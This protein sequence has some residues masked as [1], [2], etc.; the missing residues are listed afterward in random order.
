MDK[1]KMSLIGLGSA[2][3]RFHLQNL[4]GFDDVDVSVC[5]ANADR[6]KKISDENGIQGRSC[7][8]G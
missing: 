2:G 8:H 3:S 4:V 5:D 7:Q 1:R 6:L